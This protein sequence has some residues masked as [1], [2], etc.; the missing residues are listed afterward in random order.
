LLVCRADQ[1]RTIVWFKDGF[2]LKNDREDIS[3]VGSGSIIVNNVGRADAGRYTCLASNDHGNRSASAWLEIEGSQ[4]IFGEPTPDSSHSARHTQHEASSTIATIPAPRETSFEHSGTPVSAVGIIAAPELQQIAD[5]VLLNWTIPASI[6]P[7]VLFVKLQYKEAVKG[8]HWHTVAID[9]PRYQESHVIGN[10][11]TGKKYRFRVAVILRNDTS[12]TGI[13]SAKLRIRGSEAVTLPPPEGVAARSVS[14]TAITVTWQYPGYETLRVTGFILHYRQYYHQDSSS[15]VYND[16]ADGALTRSH[17]LKHLLPFT[18]Y[19]ITMEAYSTSGRG[20]IS[21]PIIATTLKVN[22]N[23]V[24]QFTTNA[25]QSTSQ[26]SGV[27]S[28]SYFGKL[29]GILGGAFARDVMVIAGGSL[30]GILLIVFICCCCICAARRRKQ[31][32]ILKES[33]GKYK[34]TC[35]RIYKEQSGTQNHYSYTDMSPITSTARNNNDNN[36]GMTGYEGL[37]AN[38]LTSVRLYENP[39]DDYGRQF[40]IS[41][42]DEPTRILDQPSVPHCPTESSGTPTRLAGSPSSDPKEQIATVRPFI[43]R[44]SPGSIGHIGQA[45]QAASYEPAVG[46]S[47]TP[48]YPLLSGVN[49]PHMVPHQEPLLGGQD[50]IHDAPTRSTPFVGGFRGILGTATKSCS[51]RDFSSSSEVDP[52]MGDTRLRQGYSPQPLPS[53]CGSDASTYGGGPSSTSNEIP[54]TTESLQ[55][56]TFKPQR[57]YHSLNISAAAVPS[58][59]QRYSN[60]DFGSPNDS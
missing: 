11:E 22:E 16:T 13:R 48:E 55:F 27:T 41:D 15:I 39:L 58:F 23:F 20:N 29:D 3:R 26:A 37:M 50:A 10:L 56:H 38:G 44:A 2:L 18:P 28:D 6:A 40:D 47:P 46:R 42:S 34:D 54:P 32:K 21:T 33:N 60:Y 30:L 31:K 14:S 35:R 52:G 51:S 9:L 36:T 4:G 24:S 45:R 59:Q 7:D 49:Q 25:P 5:S 12:L 1:A 19:E 8:G 43:R 57:N 53:V 17:T